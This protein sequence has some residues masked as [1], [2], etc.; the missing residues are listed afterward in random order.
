MQWALW[1]ASSCTN[2][3]YLVFYKSA[4]FQCHIFSPQNIKRNVLGFYLDNR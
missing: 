2:L 4:K 3:P 1:L